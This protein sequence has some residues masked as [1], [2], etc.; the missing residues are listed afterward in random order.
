[1]R[2]AAGCDGFVMVTPEYDHSSGAL[3]N[4]LDFL[5]NE[6]NKSA[7]LREHP[8]QGIVARPANHTP[9]PGDRQGAD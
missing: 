9:P 3:K 7:S 8:C 4:A 6:W 2:R 5:Y 1:M